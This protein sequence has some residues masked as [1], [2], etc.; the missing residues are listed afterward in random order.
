MEKKFLNEI[1]MHRHC[2]V[3]QKNLNPLKSF[4]HHI[5]PTLKTGF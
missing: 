5:L 3:V 4:N 2:R 1:R